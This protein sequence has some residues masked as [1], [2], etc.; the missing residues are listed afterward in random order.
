MK[1]SNQS[2]S[3]VVTSALFFAGYQSWHFFFLLLVALVD[4]RQLW[5]DLTVC[6]FF[7]L[8]LS[9]H[10]QSTLECDTWDLPSLHHPWERWKIYDASLARSSQEQVLIINKMCDV[11]F[12]VGRC[13]ILSRKGFTDYRKMVAHLN[14]FYTQISFFFREK[15]ET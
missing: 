7:Y 9:D 15:T 14:K 10:Q 5:R 3:S 6:F 12:L 13:Q 4:D 2:S 1:W 11:N 8:S